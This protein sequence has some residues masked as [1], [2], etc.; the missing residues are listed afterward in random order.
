MTDRIE[1]IINQ[2]SLRINSE[3]NWRWQYIIHDINLYTKQNRRENDFSWHVWCIDCN[4]TTDLIVINSNK[5]INEVQIRNINDYSCL[6]K[7]I[8]QLSCTHNPFANASSRRRSTH[9]SRCSF[10]CINLTNYSFT[11]KMKFIF[12]DT[13]PSPIFR[14]WTKTD[15][16][17]SELWQIDLFRIN[18]NI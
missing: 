6:S 9:G 18:I 16:K 14:P 15:D 10:T 7:V 4:Q 13:N 3:Y 11:S 5:L 1:T 8:I 12:I 2:L 17:K